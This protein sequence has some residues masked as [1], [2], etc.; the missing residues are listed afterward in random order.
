M[1]VI[2]E[3]QLYEEHRAAEAGPFDPCPGCKKFPSNEGGQCYHCFSVGGIVDEC[4]EC[5]GKPWSDEFL[6]AKE[7]FE[8]VEDTPPKTI[9]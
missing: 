8:D 5:A 1:C 4:A 6:A 7:D 3:L 2:C 9:H